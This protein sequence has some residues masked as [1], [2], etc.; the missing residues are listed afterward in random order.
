MNNDF[1]Q[2]QKYQNNNEYQFINSMFFGEKKNETISQVK[3]ISQEQEVKI[4]NNK[5]IKAEE[6]LDINSFDNAVDVGNS[7]LS[8]IRILTTGI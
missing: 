5:G 1:H 7:L 2:F 4:E 3:N 8:M 6:K